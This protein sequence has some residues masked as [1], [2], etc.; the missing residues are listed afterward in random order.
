MKAVKISTLQNGAYNGS[1]TTASGNGNAADNIYESLMHETC[2]RC[3]TMNS[4]ND[5]E[6][7]LMQIMVMAVK[8]GKA[9]P[10]MAQMV[11]EVRQF[12]IEKNKPQPQNN[13]TNCTFNNNT[14][15]NNQNNCNN[16]ESEAIEN[17]FNSEIENLTINGQS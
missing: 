1:G 11:D 17:H 12:F 2:E 8:D 14:N 6:P 13:Y 7:L 9:T 15:S 3:K 5:A 10:R 4:Y 16:V